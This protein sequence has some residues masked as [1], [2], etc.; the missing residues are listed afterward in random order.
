MTLSFPYRTGRNI[1]H[2]L[3][4]FSFTKVLVLRFRPN[5][6]VNCVTVTLSVSVRPN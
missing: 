2:S 6:T 1:G 5:V 4:R 3:L